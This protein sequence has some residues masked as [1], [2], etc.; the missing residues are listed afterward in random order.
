[1][2]LNLD[3]LKGVQADLNSRGEGGIFLYMNKLNEEDDIR[4]LPPLPKLNGLYFVEQIVWWI[5]EKPY[6]SPATFDG[7][8]PIEAEV[9]AAEKLAKSDKDLKA[10]LDDDK[11]LKRKSRF[12][13]PILQLKCSFNDDNECT[14]FEIVDGKAKVLVAGPVLMKAINK[15]VTSRLFQNGTEDGLMDR[16]K[17]Y[18]LLLGKTGKGLSTDYTAEGWKTP[19]EMDKKYY[20]EIPD[21]IDITKKEIKS[22]AFLRGIIRNYLY[23]EPLPK[24]E[25]PEEAAK[26]TP[27]AASG[28]GGGS[29]RGGGAADKKETA[30]TGKTRT[31][32]GGG[33]RNLADDLKN[34]DD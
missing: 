1:M 34:L 7:T 18:N 19:L 12:L 21:V 6:V 10:L 22:D 29:R 16:V 13:M 9:K 4:L 3:A 23:G 14:K 27:A 5:N 24:E 31:G 26:A 28:G 15:V 11:Q 2:A 17:G 25:K 32:A 20:E 33:R 8:C 30:E